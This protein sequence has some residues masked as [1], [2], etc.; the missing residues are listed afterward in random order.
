M[1]QNE[2]HIEYKDFFKIIKK[3]VYII[4][5]I[6]LV[7]VG[8]SIFY[9]TQI[10]KPVYEAKASIIIGN[11]LDNGKSQFSID[12]VR[13]NQVYMETYIMILKTNVVAERTI[14]ALGLDISTDNLKRHIYGSPQ[15]NTQ[16]M[17]IRIRWG[18]PEKALLILD[19]L[20][21]VFI[22]EA[23]RI[24][25]TYTMKILEKTNPRYI[26][27]ISNKLYYLITLI[28]SFLICLLVILMMQYFDN[29]IKSEEDIERYLGTPVIGTIPRH[30]KSEM[31][32]FESIKKNKFPS[33]DAY[34]TLRTNLFYISNKLN[35]KTIIITSASPREGKSTSASMLA[36]VLARGGKRTLLMDCDLRRP[37]MH[38]IFNLDKPGLSDILMGES[39][40]NDGIHESLLENLY[41]LTAGFK[42]YN[43]VEL[44]SSH[45]MKELILDLREIFD[46]IIMDTPPIGIL[47]EA[48]VLSQFSD[49]FI[50]IVS[51]GESD[52]DTTIKAQK[53]IQFSEGRLLGALL[54][55][56]PISKKDRKYSEYYN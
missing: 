20:T 27:V 55:K 12:D 14:N 44:V 21:E 50:M 22:E 43:P 10:T 33:L 41:V 38:E 37:T 23:V 17:E 5:P 15:P 53:L 3:K 35:I 2:L 7:T 28:G 40:L 54:N 26:E 8:L 42:P 36:V 31:S 52:K 6:I 19:T 46:Y 9:R 39:E 4:I 25:P 30:K 47:P 45:K 56:V 1:K 32:V 34:R 49:G 16:F 48:Q 11:I 51:S 24:Y 29:T 18:N 13:N